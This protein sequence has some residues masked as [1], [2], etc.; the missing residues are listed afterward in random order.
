[1]SVFYSVIAGVDSDSRQVPAPHS[2]LRRALAFPFMCNRYFQAARRMA[3]SGT[4]RDSLNDLAGG[5]E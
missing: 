2:L 4:A 3:F 1:M 5:A